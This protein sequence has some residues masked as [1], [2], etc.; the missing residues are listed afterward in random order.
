MESKRNSFIGELIYL[1]YDNLNVEEESADIENF[2]EAKVY[3]ES[4]NKMCLFILGMLFANG[5]KIKILNEDELDISDVVSPD[6]SIRLNEVNKSFS[7]MAYVWSR[8]GDKSFPSP[9]FSNVKIGIDKL[10]ENVKRMGLKVER[11][12]SKPIDKKIF[13]ICPVRNAT[14][15]QKKWMEDFVI[16]KYKEGYT[17][18]APHLHTVQTDLFGGYAICKQNAEALA[19]SEEVNIYYD[20]SSTGTAFDLGVAYA[21][22]KPLVLLNEKDIVFDENNVMDNIIESWPFNKKDKVKKLLYK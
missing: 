2:K 4:R 13:L 16:E 6:G 22:N 3:L 19:S 15:E 17:I 7:I 5:V 10:V 8:I 12:N 1:N 21:L 14:P 18:H 11:I 9:D 20:K